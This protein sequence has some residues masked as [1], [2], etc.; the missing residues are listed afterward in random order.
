MP[1]RANLKMELMRHYRKCISSGARSG[2]EL[3]ERNNA[4]LRYKL[5]PVRK[6]MLAYLFEADHRAAV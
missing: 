6:Q 1:W 2:A 5:A 3:Q 4:L